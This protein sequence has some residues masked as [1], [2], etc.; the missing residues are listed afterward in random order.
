MSAVCNGVKTEGI[1]KLLRGIKPLLL[2]GLFQPVARC[3]DV[4]S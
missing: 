4:I 2:A 1:G 3:L